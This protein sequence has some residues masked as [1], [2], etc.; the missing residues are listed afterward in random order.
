MLNT[1]YTDDNT[2]ISGMSSIADSI[3]DTE[4]DLKKIERELVNS[5]DINSQYR[6]E[7][8]SNISKEFDKDL[9]ALSASKPKPFD[10]SSLNLFEN[11]DNNSQ[12]TKSLFSEQPYQNYQEPQYSPQ[13]QYQQPQQQPMYQ[14]Q[15]VKNITNEAR[16]QDIIHGV[17]NDL[18][19]SSTHSFGFDK[20]NEMDVKMRKLEM[21]ESLIETLKDQDVN[22]SKIISVGV[23]NS[24]DEI[25][26]VMKNLI[27]KLDRIRYEGLGQNVVLCVVEGIEWMF[28]GKKEYMG[29]RPN[30]TGWNKTVK[31]ELLPRMRY[32]L[33]EL[34][35][36]TIRTCH[37]ITRMGLELIPSM[38]L[39]SKSKQS[40]TNGDR[41]AVED[42]YGESMEKLNAL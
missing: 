24:T 32:D 41:I 16:N 31:H 38:F 27:L 21:I 37:P 42:N 26:I 22:V 34:T 30:L 20:E 36:S 1:K 15:V 29:H 7:D 3:D 6:Q 17:C 13:Q 39:H 23:E 2:L 25:D 33:S 4:L 18:G 9:E 28:D 14:N 12:D 10:T 8:L 19:N 11:N 35:S 40:E 5:N